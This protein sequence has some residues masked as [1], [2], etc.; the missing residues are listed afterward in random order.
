[1]SEW[2]ESKR[3]FVVETTLAGKTIVGLIDRGRAKGYSRT[4]V[5]V[6]LASGELCVERLAGVRLGFRFSIESQTAA[7]TTQPKRG[8]LNRGGTSAP[9]EEAVGRFE[10]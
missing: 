5:F 3:S 7:G 2:I 10:M 8:R 6:L 1:M 4:I 9:L